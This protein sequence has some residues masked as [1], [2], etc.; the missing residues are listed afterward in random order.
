MYSKLV[1]IVKIKI[2]MTVFQLCIEVIS[3]RL[4]LL[5]TNLTL[6]VQRKTTLSQHK[7]VLKF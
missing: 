2:S 1:L 7:F 4:H 3:Y 5:L 6:H